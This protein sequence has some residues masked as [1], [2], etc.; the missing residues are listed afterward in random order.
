MR[1]LF[2]VLSSSLLLV[3]WKCLGLREGGALDNLEY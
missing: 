1:Y 3:T 2:L